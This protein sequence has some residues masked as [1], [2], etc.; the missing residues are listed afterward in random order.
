MFTVSLHKKTFPQ[1]RNSIDSITPYTPGT[2]VKKASDKATTPL[3]LSSNENVLNSPLT[4]KEWLDCIAEASIYPNSAEHPLTKCLSSQLNLTP[5]NIIFGNGSDECFQLIA[6]SYLNPGDTVLSSEHTFSVYKS[7]TQIMDA[8][9]VSVPMKN[10]AH[11][12]DAYLNAITEKTKLIFISN[13]NN[14]TGTFSSH[15]K[16]IEFFKKVPSHILI[17]LD[18]AYKEY[19]TSEA[20]NSSIDLIKVFNNLVITRT[21]SKIYGLAGLRIG[22][23][24]GNPKIIATIQKVKPPFNVN[25]IALNAAHIALTQKQSFIT[26]SIDLNAKGHAFYKQ[27]HFSW[28][29]MHLDSKANFV[30]FILKQHN[31]MDVYQHCLTDGI[32][33]RALNS[34]GLPNAIRITIGTAKQNQRV[35][36]SLSNFF[37]LNT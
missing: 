22:Y 24:L 13:P 32:A 25:Q 7:V 34:F 10:Y 37:K 18:E 27:A 11:D 26:Q 20:C 31:A 9:Y 2:A 5:S 17:V 23:A 35:A 1:A 33:I 4:D 6:Q 3:K 28:P 21:F 16:L 15:D 29:V 12:F 30:T 36:D 19:V 8:A 14:P